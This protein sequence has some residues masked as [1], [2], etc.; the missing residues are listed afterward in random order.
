MQKKTLAILVFAVFFVGGMFFVTHKRK[1]AFAPKNNITPVA[2][3]TVASTTTTDL[4]NGIKVTGPAGATVA[5]ESVDTQQGP[6]APSLNHTVVYTSTLQPEA[7]D[8]LK[9]NIASTVTELKKNS[10]QGVYWLQLGLDYKI[11]GDYKAAES[12][13][14]YITKAFPKNEV[15]FADLGDLY[16]NF[17]KDY[18]KAESNYKKA[19]AIKPDYIDYYRDLYTL[20]RY[21]YK[22]DTT[23]AADILAQ[24]LS[25]NPNN[26]DLLTLQNTK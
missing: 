10:S 24:G 15:A 26:A 16:Q 6:I 4:G 22:T 18:P 1:V 19:I 9:K 17:L 2:T 7:I 5:I 25:A 12:V 23:A 3:S 20:Y 13:W 14:V 21:Q 11:A 8:A